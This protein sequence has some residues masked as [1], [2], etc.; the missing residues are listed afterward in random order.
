[1]NRALID[2]FESGW[3]KLAEAI[4]GLTPQDRCWTPPAGSPPELGRWS[5][6]QVVIHTVDSD[7]EAINRMKRMVAM[8][9]PVLQGYDETAFADR[10]RYHEQSVDDAIAILRLARRQWARVLRLLPDEAF[11]RTGRHSSEGVKRLGTMVGAYVEHL[12]HHV[13]F[14]QAK[15]KALGK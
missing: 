6:H 13:R 10:L 4:R 15:R 9:D 5:I 12:E 7:L 3:Q 1:M 2:Q 8:E 11:E 14:I